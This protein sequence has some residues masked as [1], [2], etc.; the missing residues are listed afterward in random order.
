MS[1]CELFSLLIVAFYKNPF[2]SSFFS[3]LKEMFCFGIES[4]LSAYFNFLMFVKIFHCIIII[5][6]FVQLMSL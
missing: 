3:T 5:F 2:F 4:T 6:G 1:A